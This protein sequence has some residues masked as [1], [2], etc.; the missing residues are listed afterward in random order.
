MAE[1]KSDQEVSLSSD[2]LR[3]HLPVLDG[4]RGLAIIMVL[5]HHSTDMAVVTTADKA[6][7]LFL[8]WGGFGVDL[9]FVLSGFLI[10]G[11][12]ADTRGHKGY[13]KSFYARRIL[14]IFPLYYAICL[15]SF[16]ILPNL[17][18]MLANLPG[19]SQGVADTVDSKLDRFGTVGGDQWY[20]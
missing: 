4:I 15:F 11:I 18:P 20:Y 19:V 5:F 10:T 12:L 7:T 14:R 13:F 8:H 6:A 3:G 2:S 16:V 9:F 17:G 1:S